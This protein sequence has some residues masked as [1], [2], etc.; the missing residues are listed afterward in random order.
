MGRIRV[1]IVDDSA[2]M[3]HALGRLLGEV[4]SIE[5]VGVASNGVDGLQM[6]ADLHPDVITLD[7]EMPV[8]DGLGMLKRLMAESPTRVV[9]L[10]N[11]TTASARV[12]LDALE[13]GAI[14]FVPKPSGSLSIDLGRVGE[15]LVGKIEAA[16][17]MPEAAFLRPRRKIG[18][19]H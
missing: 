13:F 2:F 7:V 15:E 11:L 10:S 16:A 1:L 9:M 17:G 5:V 19:A 14:D 6:A 8:L 18:R 3:R 4:P 12:T